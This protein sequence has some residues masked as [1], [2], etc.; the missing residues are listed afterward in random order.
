[1]I[2]R[3]KFSDLMA[4]V[5]LKSASSVSVGPEIPKN[6]CSQK[7]YHYSDRG[8]KRIV[9]KAL[10]LNVVD[11]LLFTTK[12]DMTNESF[13]KINNLR[14]AVAKDGKIRAW[15]VISKNYVENGIV[16]IVL[17]GTSNNVKSLKTLSF[18]WT[19]PKIVED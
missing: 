19:G 13:K 11:V 5:D 6:W 10:K 3:M 1:M 8:F 16:D 14:K 7:F 17:P 15:A 18:A 4:K 9:N 12:H 2:K